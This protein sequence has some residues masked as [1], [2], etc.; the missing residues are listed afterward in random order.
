VW[1]EKNAPINVAQPV[2]DMVHEA[3]FAVEETIPIRCDV[4]RWMGAFVGVFSH[5]F[6]T[7]SKGGGTFELK[8]PPGSYE[9]VAWHELYGRKT[10]MVEVP[11]GGKSDANFSFSASDKAAD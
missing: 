4:H 8:L 3:K 10:M 7:V 1:A 9:I 5:P 6:H 2:K 11:E